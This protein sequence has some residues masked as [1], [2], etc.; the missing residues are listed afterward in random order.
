MASLTL[1]EAIGQLVIPWMPGAYTSTS[2]PEFEEY[3]RY[4]EEAGVGGVSISIGLPHSYGAKLNAL[5]SRAKIPLLVT[6]DFENGG[7]GMRINHSYALPTLL[8]Q[9]GG[10]SFPPTMAFGAIGDE[11]FTRE[12]ARITALEARAV[13]VHL[14][15]APVLD[16]NSNP[17]NPVINTRSFGED[18]EDVARLGAAYLAGAREGG[19]L[20]TAKHFPGH[21]DTRTDSHVELPVVDADRERLESLELIPFRM[22]VEAGVDAVMTAHV[23][24]PRIL[25][26]GGPPATLSPYFL[27]ELLRKDMGFDGLLLTDALRMGAISEGYGVGESAV[28]ALEA[29]A[30]ILLAPGDV[31]ETLDAVEAAVGSGRITRERLDAS[32]ERI[33]EMKA[34]VGLHKNRLVNLDRIEEVV[35]SGAHLAFA[36]SAAARSITLPRDRDDLVPVDP[37]RVRRVLHVVYAR[38]ADL[39]AGT[40]LG[41]VLGEYFPAVTTRRLTP[42]SPTTD[43]QALEWDAGAVDLV[44]VSAFVPPRS[45]AGEVAV[46]E[47]LVRFLAESQARRP[48]VVVS[49]G[50]PYLLSSFPEVGTYLLAW[51]SREVSQQAA[52]RA[53]V[54]EA[55]ISGT[56]PV[57]IPPLH[58]RGE[59]LRR[60]AV[61]HVPRL[62]AEADQLLEVGVVRG[63]TPVGEGLVVDRG[64][65]PFTTSVAEA[66]EGCRLRP[67]LLPWMELCE[68]VGGGVV[69]P[70]E[71]DPGS[72]GMDAEALAGLDSLLLA[73]L[74]DSASPGLAIAVGRH[75]KLVRLRGYGRLDWDSDALPATPASI[76]DMASLAKVSTT[77]TAAMILAE[78]GRL[79]LDA[80]V[81]SYL[82]WWS[83]G[84][85]RK[86]RVTVRQLLVHRGGLPPF[87]RFYETVEGRQAFQDTIGGLALQYEP[88]DSTVYSDIGMMTV[89][90]IVEAITGTRLD[91]FM[92]RRVWS[93][94]G[95]QDTG[96]NPDPALLPRIAPTEVD[97]YYRFTHVHGVVHDEN[98][99]ALGG[100]AGHAG[101]FSS[102]RDLAVLAQTLL[103]GGA[104]P[105][106]DGEAGSGVPCSV[107]RPGPIRIVAPTTVELFTR[108]WDE[109]SSRAMGWDT[110]S[111][112]SSS[113]DYLSGRAF[114]HT[115]FTGTSLWVDPELD[116]FVVLLTSRTNPSRENARHVPLR[117]SV[118]DAVATA[119]TDHVVVKRRW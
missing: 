35:G 8:P 45:G 92:A 63:P 27:T 79:E 64:R 33:L 99:Y 67:E 13:G 57:T 101:V 82:P 54:G 50:N 12:Y 1:R 24:V 76:W 72:V 77:T 87:V 2:G 43:Y 84:D 119:V 5:Q 60:D 114:G 110:P 36:D 97:D 48:T 51:G 61:P 104:A 65:D 59:G 17:L 14:N 20:T 40:A 41:N 10:T 74:A 94:L 23:A 42:E 19:I 103:D 68:A 116:L 112:G 16:V 106:C 38:T 55:A 102:A 58:A 46:P 26:P 15:F 80:P 34:R 89:A 25:G 56:L 96:F 37:R 105:P 95:M 90:F 18:P 11:R 4:V 85:P 49:L 113:G 118:N 7:P 73:A 83:A 3:L 53:L 52:A 31:W 70:L 30:D 93:P 22:A 32:V 75:G 9:G 86:E 71:V 62:G 115:G 6:S 111:E 107:P 88:G 100:V 39:T 108:R 117:R 21:G 78:A 47:P 66:R 44:L 28:L 29:G 81:V 91:E 109:S 69:S 98:A